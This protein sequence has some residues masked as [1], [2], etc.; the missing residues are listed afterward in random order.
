MMM[1]IHWFVSRV[2]ERL[3]LAGYIAIGSVLALLLV[4]FFSWQPTQQALQSVEDANNAQHMPVNNQNPEE[5]LSQFVASFPN[6]NNRVQSIQTIIDTAEKMGLGLDNIAYKTTQTQ[7]DLLSHYHVD[8]NLIGDY[9]DV[10][11]YLAA[12][13]AKMPN[14]SLDTLVMDRQNIEQDFIR[15]RVRLTL[16]FSQ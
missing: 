7:D 9:V 14:V 2:L 11:Q 10:R 15:T 6:H 4:Y 3:G 1:R 16:H 13:M 8:F 5:A 12:V